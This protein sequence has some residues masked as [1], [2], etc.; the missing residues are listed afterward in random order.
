MPHFV[1][2]INPLETKVN[3]SD[4]DTCLYDNSCHQ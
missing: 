4:I 1:T 3:K 2:K